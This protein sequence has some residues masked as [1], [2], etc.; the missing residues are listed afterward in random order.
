MKPGL[1]IVGAPKCGTSAWV[2]YL[3]E[4]P[5]IAFSSTKEPHHFSTDFPDRGVFDRQD[6]L[7]LFAETGP[8]EI[9]GEAS[10][11]YLYSQVA[12]RNIREFNPEAKII[13]LLRDQAEQL[14]SLHNQYVFNGMEN[15]TDFAEAWRLSGKRDRT[16]MPS[17]STVPQLLNYR[18]QGRF[19]PQVERYFAEFPAKQIRVFHFRDWTSDPRATYLEILRFLRLEDDGRTEFEP[20]NEAHR[21][22]IVTLGRFTQSPPRWALKLSGVLKRITG[23]DRPPLV[24]RIR[25]LNWDRGYRIIGPSPAVVDEIRAFYAGDN[26]R[27]ESCI[28]RARSRTTSAPPSQPA[29]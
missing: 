7:S 21:H 29:D 3:G 25:S 14:P 9:V 15:I 27:V 17:R 4:H 2:Q 20:I 13:I 10:V 22:K 24:D 8:A 5:K 28:T 12:A 16:N 1:F 18:E 6:Y 26:A 23:R 11:R 19:S